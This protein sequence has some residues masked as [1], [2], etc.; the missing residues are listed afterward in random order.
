[1]PLYM[2]IRHKVEGLTTDAVQQKESF[3]MAVR[4]RLFYHEGESTMNISSRQRE[5]LAVLAQREHWFVGE[6]VSALGV[7]HTAV[8]KLLVRL[9]RQCL[10][11]RQEDNTDRRYVLV[12]LTRFGKTKLNG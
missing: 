10:I 4:K 9:E 3:S 2:N 7:S 12:S 1:M 8:T 5:V 11:V 6:L